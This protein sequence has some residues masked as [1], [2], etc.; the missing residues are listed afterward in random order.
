MSAFVNH[1]MKLERIRSTKNEKK[2]KE[3][4]TIK[5]PIKVVV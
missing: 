2:L 5:M 4:K 1:V 3:K